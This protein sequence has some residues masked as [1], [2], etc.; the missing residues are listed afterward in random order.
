MGLFSSDPPCTSSL[1]LSVRRWHGFTGLTIKTTNITSRFEAREWYAC[2]IPWTVI[3]LIM[4]VV[5]LDEN[6]VIKLG[7]FGLSKALGAANFTNT[8]VGVHLLHLI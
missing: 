7:D 1:P 2:V 5:F 6:Q 4:V 3:V 8:Y